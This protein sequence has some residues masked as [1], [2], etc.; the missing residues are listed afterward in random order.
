MVWKSCNA[1]YPLTLQILQSLNSERKEWSDLRT[2]LESKLADS[3]KLNSSLRLELDKVR[4]D[5]STT[6]RDLRTQ[7]DKASK[8]GSAGGEWKTRCENLESDNQALKAELREQ[9]QVT[10]EVRQEASAFLKEMKAISDRSSQS[11]EREE[12]LVHQVQRLEEEVKDWK[13]RYA[14]TKT[15]L[16]TL[17][18]SSMGVSIQQPDAGQYVKDGGLTSADGLVKDVHVTKFQIAI[19]ELLRTARVNEPA[20][21]LDYMKAV[22]ISVRHVTQD[23][24][25]LASSEDGSAQRRQALK[26][27]VSATANNLI[28]ASKNFAASKGL[29]PVSLLD[30]AA[31]HLTSAVVELI[32]LVKIRPAPADELEDDDDGSQPAESSGYFS[33]QPGRLSGGESV[34]S[35]MSSPRASS[36]RTKSHGN[37]S[38]AERRSTSTNGL[39]NG[40]GLGLSMNMGFGL[41]KQDTEIEELKVE[42]TNSP[43]L[44]APHA[45]VP[46]FYLESQTEGLV[47]SIQSLVGSVRA[48][49]GVSIIRDHTTDIA[50]LVGKVL[51]S[52]D[53]AITKTRNSAL[54]DAAEPI[55]RT[56]S[57]CR[58]RL[59]D[60]NAESATMTDPARLKDFN[61]RLPP[62]AFEIARETKELVHRVEQIYNEAAAEDDD[63]R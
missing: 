53:A 13:S 60:A 62:M 7:M 26:T 21:V 28:T 30:A 48:E 24:G 25:D 45:D 46:Q 43:S 14:R 11:W 49:D 10:N 2:N 40:N 42:S 51:S 34:Y 1:L 23:M 9:Q 19:D 20:S 3:L 29:S 6:E 4:T 5:H 12:H 16:R 44:I 52:T 32:R 27:R 17:R 39:P 56:L 36:M 47:H 38:W 37:N 59:L 15:Q 58:T 63:F 54:R 57:A 18:A 35:S 55:M 31:S 50:T 22:V 33:I 41:R 61:N 8:Q